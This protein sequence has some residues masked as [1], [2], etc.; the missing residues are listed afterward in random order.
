MNDLFWR[1]GSGMLTTAILSGV[2]VQRPT[3]NLCPNNALEPICN[4]E[5]WLKHCATGISY[6]RYCVVPARLNPAFS[7]SPGP[8]NQFSALVRV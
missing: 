8:Q 2:A 4:S 1:P 7:A 3:V 6:L 5:Q